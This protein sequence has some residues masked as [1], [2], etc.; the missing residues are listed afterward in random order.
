MRLSKRGICA[1]LSCLLLPISAG[2]SFADEFPANTRIVDAGIFEPAHDQANKILHVGSVKPSTFKMLGA[3][4]PIRLEASYNERID[5]ESVL[6]YAMANSL[7]IRVTQ[8]SAKYQKLQLIEQ[9]ASALPIPSVGMFYGQTLQNILTSQAHALAA[10]FQPTILLPVFQGGA[11]VY[12]F[13]GQVYR[14]KGWHQSL[15]TSMNHALFDV[16]QKYEYLVLQR[17]LL[18]IRAKAVE[19]SERILQANISVSQ[20]H[21]DARYGEMQSRTHLGFDRQALKQQQLNY[22]LAALDLAHSMNAPMAGNFIPEERMIA[23][24]DLV[25]EDVPLSTL[26]DIALEHRPELRQYEY[27]SLAARRNI[28]VAASTL[29]PNAA[30]Y[31]QFTY[32]ETNIH[33]NVLAEEQSALL[34]LA[35]Q[36]NGTAAGASGGSNAGAGVFGG[37]FQTTQGGY[38]LN[39]ELNY[40]GIPTMANVVAVRALS[41]QTNLQANQELQAVRQELRTDYATA[42]TAKALIDNSAYGVNTGKEAMPLAE[43]EL[44]NGN[45]NNYQFLNIQEGYFNLLTAQAQSI[46]DSNVAQAKILHDIGAISVKTLTKGF[47]PS[48]PLPKHPTPRKD[49]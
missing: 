29:Y 17:S 48:D 31:G 3:L 13:I 15:Y 8:Q 4:N 30:L 10:V 45:I 6:N 38:G 21:P 1:F 26:F 28:T 36:N 39:W 44:L 43:R 20:Q 25:P 16:Y 7:P 22:R 23:E 5:L 2:P 40:A 41:R 12:A 19:T 27:F 35:A 46:Y 33:Q 34:Q 42:I 24:R 9:L 37:L 32:S 47:K 18:Q 11:Q 49:V 14:N